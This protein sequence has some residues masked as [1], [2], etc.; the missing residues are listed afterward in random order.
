[1]TTN[2]SPFTT[3]RKEVNGKRRFTVQV[4]QAGQDLS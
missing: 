3:P 1:M 4:L 2:S